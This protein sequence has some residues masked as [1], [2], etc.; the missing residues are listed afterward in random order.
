MTHMRQEYFN[1]NGVTDQNS[2]ESWME[3]GSQ[4]TWTRARKIVKKILAREEK[5]Y[6]APDVEKA[7]HE[8][9]DIFL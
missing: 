5:S 2:R 6:I 3:K 8:K 4:D 9:Y 1:G 7:I